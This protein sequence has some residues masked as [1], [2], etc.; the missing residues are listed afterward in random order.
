MTVTQHAVTASGGRSG[1]TSEPAYVGSSS[2]GSASELSVSASECVY[3]H[4]EEQ[5]SLGYTMLSLG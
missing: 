2:A 1:T 4:V 3:Q 5:I